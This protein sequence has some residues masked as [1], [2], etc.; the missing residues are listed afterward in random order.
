MP[1][2]SSVSA[3]VIVISNF[4][5]TQLTDL[6]AS[7]VAAASVVLLLRVWRPSD[8]Y[9]VAQEVGTVASA[10]GTSGG[11]RRSSANRRSGA[12]IAGTVIPVRQGAGTAAKATELILMPP[13]GRL[14]QG[15]P[16]SERTYNPERRGSKC[17]TSSAPARSCAA[18]EVNALMNRASDGVLAEQQVRKW[19]KPLAEARGSSEG[20]KTEIAH[21]TVRIPA[22]EKSV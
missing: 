1:V 19:H 16:G 9:V 4:V 8:S 21:R 14:T 11:S 3:L 22:Q 18:V 10:A 5:S 6:V 13:L 12:A 15:I 2:A 17:L 7:L 20:Q